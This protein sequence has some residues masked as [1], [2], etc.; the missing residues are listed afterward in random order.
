MRRQSSSYLYNL[1]HETQEI[2]LK[3]RKK[4]FNYL[5]IFQNI[6]SENL[7]NGRSTQI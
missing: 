3:R 5:I 4:N 1:I 2:S 6:F 7:E